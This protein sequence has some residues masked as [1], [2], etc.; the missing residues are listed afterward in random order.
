[1]IDVTKQA[2]ICNANCMD[3]YCS[4]PADIVEVDAE[5]RAKGYSIGRIGCTGACNIALE[6]F[7]GDYPENSIVNVLLS[8]PE[9][10]LNRAPMIAG[11]KSD[12]SIGM[13]K[14]G[15]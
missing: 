7:L 4:T 11:R 12:G 8:N 10:E 14:L 9:K 15:S 1:M 13:T 3:R 2:I 5:L 6:Q